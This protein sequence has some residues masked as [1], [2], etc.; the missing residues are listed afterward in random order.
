MAASSSWRSSVMAL[1]SGKPQKSIVYPSSEQLRASLIS[2]PMHRVKDYISYSSRVLNPWCLRFPPINVVTSHMIFSL[3]AFAQFC[4]STGK[5]FKG[6][7][8]LQHRKQCT[9]K[10][11]FPLSI[12]VR[13]PSQNKRWGNTQK[14]PF[15]YTNERTR[16]ELSMKQWLTLSKDDF[17]LRFKINISQ[18]LI[19]T[20][21][22]F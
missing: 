12:F 20:V 22:L 2:F 13:Q 11:T 15:K 8:K 16:V 18:Q 17:S 21:F 1:N 19:R 5:G 9:N 10:K 14:I 7:D 3:K 4:R 6:Q